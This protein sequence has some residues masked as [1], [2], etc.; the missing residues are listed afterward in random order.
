MKKNRFGGILRTVAALLLSAV[1]SVGSINAFAISASAVDASMLC[2]V[3]YSNKYTYL[4]ITPSSEGNK[5]YYSVDGSK[6]DEDSRLYKSRLRASAKVTVRIVEYDKD[7]NE[8]D[9]K[10]L[11]LKRKC[12]KPEI[13]TKQ[14]S[15][16]VEVTLTTGT[17]G[18]VIYYTTNGKKPNTKSNV[19]EKPFVVEEGATVRAVAVK[20]DWLASSYLRT[21]V[22]LEKDS[23]KVET[24]SSES[25]M[26]AAAKITS[27][28]V[29]LKVFEI[30][31]AYRV[32]NGLS[33]LKLDA[34]LCKAAEIRADELYATNYKIK[35]TRT[36]GSAWYTVLD[37]I[38]YRFSFAAEN[39][40]YTRGGQL[41]TAKTVTENWIES[42]IHR[43]NILNTYG[44][45]IGLA[46][47][48]NGDT[49]Y[50]V[51][52]FGQSK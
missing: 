1:I 45:S 16:G 13:E 7:G 12:L 8:V 15:E 10:K 48:K 17:E 35:H 44:D 25:V 33:E 41:N 27:S 3:A 37:D 28:D 38:G 50:W 51:Q 40:A 29:V 39:I 31:N 47:A 6:P 21:A 30:T 5:V 2:K 4:T 46:Y 24:A 43:N 19:Y 36:D 11:T 34:E 23:V 20:S 49:V 42:E 26:D 18:A 14:V 9:R 22:E 32:E 52:L